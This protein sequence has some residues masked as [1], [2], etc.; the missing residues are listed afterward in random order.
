M[1]GIF[2]YFNESFVIDPRNRV[3]ALVI[4]IKS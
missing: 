3:V 1:D 2:H 4:K